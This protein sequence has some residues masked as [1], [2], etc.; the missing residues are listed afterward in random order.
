M[1]NDAA[2]ELLSRRSASCRRSFP[3]RICPGTSIIAL[4]IYFG[5]LTHFG[6]PSAAALAHDVVQ[7]AK[8]NTLQKLSPHFAKK[9]SHPAFKRPLAY[10]LVAV[11]QLS[12]FY[13][14]YRTWLVA[15]RRMCG[16]KLSKISA[17][18]GETLFI[19]VISK[20]VLID[21]ENAREQ[22]KAVWTVFF[23]CKSRPQAESFLPA[24]SRERN[25]TCR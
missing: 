22:E 1:K 16:H 25:K 11:M 6:P 8:Q 4:F 20:R 23:C 12:K 13:W 10:I 2:E 14:T 18:V 17:D 3:R 9:R 19:Q 15:F 5:Y 7:A 24:N 21:V